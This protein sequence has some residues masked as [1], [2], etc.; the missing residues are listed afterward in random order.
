M[1]ELDRRGS[2]KKRAKRVEDD[3]RVEVGLDG[4]QLKSRAHN[5]FE[6]TSEG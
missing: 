5:L 4:A 2:P 1:D 3:K 6:V